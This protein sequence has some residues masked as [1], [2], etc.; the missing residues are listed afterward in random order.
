MVTETDALVV[1][2][3]SC[4]S[5]KGPVYELVRE[6]FTFATREFMFDCITSHSLPQTQLLQT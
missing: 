1:D 5:C 6:A 3:E 4:S 2:C